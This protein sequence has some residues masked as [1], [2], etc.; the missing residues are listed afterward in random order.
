MIYTSYFASK[1]PAEFKVCIAKGIPKHFKGRSIPSLAPSN[2][3]VRDWRS[4][5][6]R[7]LDERFS[8]LLAIRN[9]LLDEVEAVGGPLILC[10]YEKDRATCH[11]G[12]LA[13]LLKEL[14]DGG[15]PEWQ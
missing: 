9:F 1:A 14:F 4:A 13:D 12:V 15:I 2:P 8:S 11:R 3:F 10:C 6:K 5:Y 7:D